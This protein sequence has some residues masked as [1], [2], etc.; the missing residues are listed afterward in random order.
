MKIKV[1]LRHVNERTF[2]VV[3]KRVRSLTENVTV[4]NI[5]N[6]LE[7]VKETFQIGSCCDADLLLGLDADLFLMPWALDKILEE[8][9][10]I[11]LEKPRIHWIDFLVRDKF[12]GRVYA[13]CHL[14]DNKYSKQ[15]VESFNSLEYN[16]SVKRNESFNVKRFIKK[17]RLQNHYS[18]VKVG[19][20][21]YEQYYYHIYIKYYN[22][23]TRD[24]KSYD[25]I[26]KMIKEKQENNPQDK[27]FQVALAG[28]EEAQKT[29]NE[30]GKI[31]MWLQ[32]KDYPSKQYVLEKN[33]I[34]KEK[35][36]LLNEDVFEKY[37][38]K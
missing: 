3:E 4:I 22:R 17:N 16:S 18:K 5:P 26:Y 10:K 27:D 25:K 29:L 15:I 2:P 9:K 20:H 8:W 14:Y 21:D 13:G 30:K 23:A 31:H 36:T 24:N 34:E 33:K 7:M 37:N 38:L 6:H 19:F 32:V 35:D 12:R 11:K 1:I 28:M